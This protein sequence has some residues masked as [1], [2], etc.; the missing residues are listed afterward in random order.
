MKALNFTDGFVKVLGHRLY[1]KSIGEPKKGTVLCLHGGPGDNHWEDIH[2]A[3]IA[4]FGYKVVWYDQFGCGNSEKP[5]SYSG[6]TIERAADEA[7]EIRR[8]LRLGKCHLWGYSYGGAL[9]LQTIL[10][11]P[12]GFRSLVVSSGFASSDQLHHESMHSL[13]RL[14]AK[15]RHTIVECEAQ[16]KLKDRRYVRAVKLFT[17]K[18]VTDLRVPPYCVAIMRSQRNQKVGKAMFGDTE[19]VT[20]P[21]TGTMASWDVRDELPHIRVPTLVTVGARDIVTPKCAETIH[22]GIRGSE[23]V[24]FEKSGHDMIYKERDLYMKTVLRFLASVSK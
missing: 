9:A 12:R 22:R 14:P 3:D 21:A 11:H 15:V 10:A 24:I 6:Y 7:G 5:K 18:Y 19:T 20:A 2:M 16:R 1:Y 8:K 4:P 17:E 13:N 23:L